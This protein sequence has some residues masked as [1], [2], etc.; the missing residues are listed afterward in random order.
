MTETIPSPAVPFPNSAARS[1][2]ATRKEIENLRD[3]NHAGEIPYLIN[4]KCIISLCTIKKEKTIAIK[5]LHTIN[6]KMYPDFRDG[7]M[8]VWGW[9]GE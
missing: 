2:G 1:Q 6:Q 3:E 8:H 4:V 9:D 7:K 5:L